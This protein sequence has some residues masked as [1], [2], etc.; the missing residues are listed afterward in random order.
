MTTTTNTSAYAPLVV[1]SKFIVEK[2]CVYFDIKKGTRGFVREV[3]EGEGR[4]ARVLLAFSNGKSLRLYTRHI[5]RLSDAIVSL[6]N[7]DPFHKLGLRRALGV[8]MFLLIEPAEGESKFHGARKSLFDIEACLRDVLNQ[9]GVL[10]GSQVGSRKDY[11]LAFSP[12]REVPQSL[13]D[14]GFPSKRVF[15]V[16]LILPGDSHNAFD[17]GVFALEVG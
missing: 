12:L 15:K 6:H 14:L 4:E 3:V 8:P 13:L 10:T 11:E 17:T 1:G 5:N 7:G 16:F 2:G 9:P